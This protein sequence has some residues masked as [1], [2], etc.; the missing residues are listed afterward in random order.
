M[1]ESIREQAEQALARL[2]R[3]MEE[4]GQASASLESSVE[5][6]ISKDRMVGA[7]V[8]ARGELIELKFHTQKYRQMAP[9]ELAWAITD[10]INQARKRMFARVTQAYAQFMPEGID[11]DEVMSGTFDPSRLLGDL[12]LPFPSGAAKPFDGDRP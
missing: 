4:F 10:V 8:N 9:A 7:K 2:H 12:D 11:I 5:E 6:V 1:S 3:Q